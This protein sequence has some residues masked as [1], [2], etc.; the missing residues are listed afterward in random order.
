MSSYANNDGDDLMP[1]VPGS[2]GG[3]HVVV[4]PTGVD[5]EVRA[6]ET[7]VDALWR[8]G[9]RTRYKC[10]R[11]G[12]GACRATLVEGSV[13]YT[14]V[15]SDVVLDGPS[16]TPEEHKC[17]P[18]RATPQSDVVIEL[19]ARD[20]IVNV[21]EALGCTSAPTHT[22]THHSSQEQDLCP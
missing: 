10:R 12:C 11:G 17:L 1:P 9:Y 18:C 19:G 5:V 21:F 2:S 15:I 14:A 8:N 13:E 16:P 3:F 7:I 6:G 20:R 22:T 4:R